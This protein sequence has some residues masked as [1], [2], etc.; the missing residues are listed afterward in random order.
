VFDV[1]TGEEAFRLSAPNC[2][3]DTDVFGGVSWSPDGRYVAAGSED[4]THV[5]DV[6]SESLRYTLLGQT[7]FV[8]GVAWSPDSSRLV[9]GGSDGTARV[10]EIQET[11]VRELWSLPAQETNPWI[12]GVAFS[13]DGTRVM[14]S[15]AGNSLVKIWDIG[16]SGDAEWA[17][18][19]A[20][21]ASQVE[22]MP[23]G[24]SVAT[25]RQFARSVTIWDLQAGRELR[26]IG[27]ATDYFRFMSFDV[28]PDGSSIGLGGWS[29]PN[30]YGGAS[31]A[32]AWD[33]STGE[34]LFRIGHDLDVNEVSFSPDGEYLVTASWDGTAKI[35]DRAG[36]V[37]RVLEERGFSLHGA[38]FSPDGRLL[39]TVAIS[40]SEIPHVTI[41]DWERDEILRTFEDAYGAVFDL[42]GSRIA[43]VGPEGLVEIRDAE[44]GSSVV[45]L[46]VSTVGVGSDG[47]G[48]GSVT[49]SPDGSRIAVTHTD[50]TVRLF[51]AE[52][53]APRLVLPGFGCPVSDLAF[54]PDG[55]K[56]A[57]ASP[58][59]GLR[60]WA[61]DIDDL[62]EI[63]H[64]EVPRALTDE[65]CRQY[66]HVDQCG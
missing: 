50:G 6:G 11:G 5:W 18:L 4:A 41:W 52:T 45:E 42:S 30:D 31:A 39:A 15:D 49:F 40:G 21:E 33:T 63:A 10:W 24:R 57:S 62:L 3:S 34:E 58:C 64:R 61:L 66:L 14:A 48:R 35:I 9:T 32:R 55:R 53:G 27:P 60:I 1:R 37:L 22:F 51:D 25:S 59:G 65:E 13:P 12:F 47:A 43:M 46:H 26:T 17:N 38:R 19:P 20:P 23:D 28:S 2:C 16:P 29:R 44:S 36:G 8:P 7:G 54:S 56:L